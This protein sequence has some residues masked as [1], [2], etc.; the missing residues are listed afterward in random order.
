MTRLQ[1]TPRGS[2]QLVVLGVENTLKGRR[3]SATIIHWAQ[4]SQLTVLPRS[5]QTEK[6]SKCTYAMLGC[7]CGSKETGPFDRYL[8]PLSGL[9]H[10]NFPSSLKCFHRNSRKSPLAEVF[11]FTSPIS[12]PCPPP[13]A[14]RGSIKPQMEALVPACGGS[15]GRGAEGSGDASGSLPSSLV[16]PSPFWLVIFLSFCQVA[17]YKGLH[18]N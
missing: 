2:K 4:E 6:A 15:W 8:R 7:A 11:I 13:P 10:F 12:L 14:P 16:L 5:P 17:G 1:I 9:H 18:F 3:K